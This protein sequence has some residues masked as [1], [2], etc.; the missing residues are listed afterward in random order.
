MR[1]LMYGGVAAA[2][3]F[4]C[5]IAFAQTTSPTPPP[6]QTQTT[7]APSTSPAPSTTPAPSTQATPA[8]ATQAAP[9]PSASAST[10][11]DA[12]LRSYAAASAEMDRIHSGLGS[13][14]SATA[15]AQ[16]D[17]QMTA[18]LRTNNLDRTTYDAIAARARTD[19]ALRARIASL[20]TSAPAHSPG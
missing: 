7:P 9:T 11:T 10:Y 12:Q 5:P 4:A 15:R 6:A 2:L 20:G 14:P 1:K 8:P 19:T 17:T 18:A 13:A 16:A 3:V